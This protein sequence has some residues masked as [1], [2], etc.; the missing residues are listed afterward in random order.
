MNTENENATLETVEDERT[1]PF[2]ELQAE[3][4]A[5]KQEDE[6]IPDK[7]EDKKE[8][9]K[10]DKIS[11]AEKK[12]AEDNDEGDSEGE[13]EPDSEIELLKKDIEKSKKSLLDAQKWGTKNS[14]KVKYALKKIN[15]LIE[16]SSFTEDEEKIALE[17]RE[18]LQADS[19][20][21][22][23]EEPGKDSSH[24]IS[25]YIDI[26]KQKL[27]VMRELSDDPSVFYKKF[28]AFE[29]VLMDSKPD[30]VALL[31]DELDDLKDN[32]VKLAKRIMEIGE[33][34]YN[35]YYKEFEDS[36]GFRKIIQN[37]N[38]E[39]EKAKNSIDKLKKKLLQ[40]EDYDT[41]PKYRIREDYTDDV[42]DDSVSNSSDPFEEL[43]VEKTQRHRQG[44][45]RY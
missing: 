38:K 31:E 18:M 44:N 45:K 41:N 37:K 42:G 2:S 19:G 24:P 35:N 43:Q 28:R 16:S 8:Q 22:I 29:M 36:G 40:Y 30:E 26:A 20:V 33:E 25:K 13:E 3:K 4:L 21:E 15:T 7:P 39:L 5:E 1:D 34:N 6:I 12:A 27:E 9:T 17:L 11:K 23:E 14:Q 10:K 32:P